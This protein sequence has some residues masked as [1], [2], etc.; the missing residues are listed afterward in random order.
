MVWK[1]EWEREE[2]NI[3]DSSVWREG[4]GN[5]EFESGTIWEDDGVKR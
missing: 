3:K 1:F 4:R 5:K 2:Y